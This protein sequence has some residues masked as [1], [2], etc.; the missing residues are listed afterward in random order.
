M[1]KYRPISINCPCMLTFDSS[2]TQPNPTQS[3]NVPPPLCKGGSCGAPRARQSSGPVSRGAMGRVRGPDRNR[4]QWGVGGAAESRAGPTAV[5]RRRRRLRVL[6]GAA[7]RKGGGGMSEDKATI[8][9]SSLF[10]C[11]FCS[12][13]FHS[14][15]PV[16]IGGGALV[17]YLLLVTFFLSTC[18]IATTACFACFAFFDLY[19]LSIHAHTYTYLLPGELVR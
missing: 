17:K 11:S 2:P 1:H 12:S 18:S 10:S 6:H 7:G 9:G 15:A 13:S 16:E 5:Q 19:V 4:A 8:V 14:A 3:F